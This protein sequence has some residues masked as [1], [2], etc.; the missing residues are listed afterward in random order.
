MMW[1]KA[2]PRCRSGDL[3]LDGDDSRHC[4]QCGYIQYSSNETNTAAGLM[5][6]VDLDDGRSRFPATSVRAAAM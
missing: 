1:F 6:L 5:P 3:Y 4:M 2:C